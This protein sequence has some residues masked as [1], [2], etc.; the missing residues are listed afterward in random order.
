MPITRSADLL[1]TDDEGFAQ[2]VHGLFADL[3]A[4]LGCINLPDDFALAPSAN[5]L[6]VIA[7]WQRSLE[8][9][10]R[11]ALVG[12]FRELSAATG[13]AP[14]PERLARF[15]ATCATLGLECPADMG[16]L[17]QQY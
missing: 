8:T 4:G 11:R 5:Q 9:H 3:D 7:A 13:D 1:P 17:L 16:L 15:Q 12:L 14:L 2:P 6:S 10:R